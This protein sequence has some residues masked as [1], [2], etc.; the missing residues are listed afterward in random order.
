[1]NDDTLNTKTISKN[2]WLQ[3]RLTYN[4][5]LLIAGF[6]AFVLYCTLG[7]IIIAPHEEFEETIFEMAF[8]GIGY[9]TMM[10]V[11][12]VFYTLGWI[13]DISFNKNN[14]QL[15]R[16]RLFALGYW[17]SFSLPIL[18]I[19]SVMVRFLIWGK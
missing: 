19:L 9:I 14:S 5:G 13:V 12:N 6:I 1:M 3:K 17:F 16:E 15:F 11:A 2:W 10:C 4:K 7:P 18:L 8:Q